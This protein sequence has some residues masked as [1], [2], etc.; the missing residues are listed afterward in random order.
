MF[1]S[2]I[3]GTN[4]EKKNKDAIDKSISIRFSE[5]RKPL[6]NK[7]GKKRESH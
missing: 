1:N 4:A 3:S 7:K 2:Y 5:K 6:I